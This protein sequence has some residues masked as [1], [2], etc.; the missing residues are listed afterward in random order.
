MA[1]LPIS[2]Y[3]REDVVQ[4]S[5][6]LLGKYLCT[7]IRDEITK[8]IIVE[9]EAYAGVTDRASHAYGGRRTNRTEIMYV[10][11]SVAYVYLCYGIHELFN[12]V[13]NKKDVP[14]A[15]LIR[16]VEPIDGI[17]I[18]LKRRKKFNVDRSLT[19]GPGAL[20]QALALTREHM[21]LSVSDKSTIWVED[22]GLSYSKKE[23]IAS[24]R[25]GVAY[26]QEDAK[27]PWRFR[28]KDSCW[29]SLAK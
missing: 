12:I 25:V 7:N 9:T 13:T 21:G 1:K 20:S 17:E 16:A 5:K 6:D 24:P 14:H 28:V 11:G 4:I 26:A 3:T 22:K 2:F 15:I 10:N 27:L 19:A 23:V 8:G 18:M 29:T